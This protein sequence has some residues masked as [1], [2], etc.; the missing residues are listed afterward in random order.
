[1]PNLHS[2]FP[3]IARKLKREAP[4]H[5]IA[6]SW[7]M[8]NGEAG[9]VKGKIEADDGGAKVVGDPVEY[10]VDELLLGPQLDATL[11]GD[12]AQDFDC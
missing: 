5:G 10:L 7:T 9:Q 2:W 11:A 6:A 8:P 3:Q 12:P 4:F 1:M